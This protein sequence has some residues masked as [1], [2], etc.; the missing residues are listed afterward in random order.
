M[1]TLQIVVLIT[2]AFLCGVLTYNAILSKKRQKFQAEQDKAIDKINTEVEQFEQTKIQ[3]DQELDDRLGN[4]DSINT[5]QTEALKLIMLDRIMYL[6]KC[7]TK[8]GEI[9]PD[10]RDRLYKMHECYYDELGGNETN[11]IIS[12]VDKLPLANN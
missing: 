7:Y 5:A 6:K 8:D 2:A 10:D 3:K 1:S 12:S 4:L 9:S 11:S